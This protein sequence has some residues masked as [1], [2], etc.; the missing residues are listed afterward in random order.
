[1]PQISIEQ[2]LHNSLLN[3][4]QEVQKLHLLELFQLKHTA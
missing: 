3:A 1:M 2:S 4:A